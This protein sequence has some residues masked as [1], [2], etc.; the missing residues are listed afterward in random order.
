MDQKEPLNEEQK[1]SFLHDEG[2]S[3][4]E[5]IAT[6][7]SIWKGKFKEEFVII[8]FNSNTKELLKEFYLIRDLKHKRIIGL[9]GFFPDI[10]AIVLEYGEGGNVG[11][12]LKHCKQPI[13]WELRFK[14]ALQTAEFVEFIHKKGV[15]HRHLEVEHLQLTKDLDIKVSEFGKSLWTEDTSQK[16]SACLPFQF[17]FRQFGTVLGKLLLNGELVDTKKIFDSK[18]KK[19]A[20]DI[21]CSLSSFRRLVDLTVHPFVTFDFIMVCCKSIISHFPKGLANLDNISSPSKE[22]QDM[23]DH[24]LTIMEGRDSLKAMESVKALIEIQPDK[25]ILAYYQHPHQKTEE[26]EAQER[27]EKDMEALHLAKESKDMNGIIALLNST[28]EEI[29]LEAAKL[30]SSFNV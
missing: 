3:L 15:V 25:L 13:E 6:D 28:S 10:N 5:K 11:D 24:H 1:K 9:K 19:L 21:P 26:E 2:I 7:G 12:F 8:K 30:L 16:V 18:T 20:D 27:L 4:I 14:W 23:I 29:R 22:D 17:D